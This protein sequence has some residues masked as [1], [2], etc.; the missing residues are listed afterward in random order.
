MSGSPIH[1]ICPNLQSASSEDGPSLLR[2]MA[3][4]ND[5]HNKQGLRPQ[6]AY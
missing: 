2:L 6:D 3:A 4:P 1:Y 5:S